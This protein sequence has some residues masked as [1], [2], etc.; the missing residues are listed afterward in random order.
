[1]LFTLAACETNRGDAIAVKEQAKQDVHTAADHG[2]RHAVRL[3]NNVRDGI[4]RNSRALRDWVLTPPPDNSPLYTEFATSNL[5]L[6]GDQL[7]GTPVINLYEWQ[8]FVDFLADVKGKHA[9]GFQDVRRTGAMI[10]VTHQLYQGQKIHRIKGMRDN[11]TGALFGQLRGF[12]TAG[13]GTDDGIWWGEGGK[14]GVDLVLDIEAFWHAFLNP[15][16][17]ATGIGQVIGETKGSLVWQRL[18]VKAWQGP[19]RIVH[20]LT[21]F[22]LRLRIRVINCD[23]PTVQQEPRRPSAT[24]DTAADNCCLH[25]VTL[26]SSW[27]RS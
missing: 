24:D 6:C 20:D 8:P 12:E 5:T 26:R 1:M 13:G 25:G 7:T 10:G 3:A 23:V 17:A 18:V 19:S 11:D 27:L 22:A 4:K 9:H 15:I 2:H 16:R 14:V 21:N